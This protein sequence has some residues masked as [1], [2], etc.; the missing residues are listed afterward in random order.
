MAGID[1]DYGFTSIPEDGDYYSSPFTNMTW[2]SANV[3]EPPKPAWRD[4]SLFNFVLWGIIGSSF[5]VL[6]MIGNALSFISFQRDRRTAAVTLLQCLACSDFVLLITVFATDDIPY[7]CSYTEIC[8]N[9]WRVW[10]YI[11]YIWILT[12]MSHM[13]SIWFVV[14]I[15]CNR[16][17]AVC[18]PH[19]MSRFWSIPRTVT[20]AVGVVFLVLAFN[21][22]RFFE[23][24]IITVVKDDNITTYQ[25]E[26]RTAFAQTYPY[27]HVYKAYLVN[28][29]LILMPLFTLILLT[30]PILRAVHVKRR[31]EGGSQMS[32]L[33][34]ASQEITFVLSMVLVVTILCQTPLAI[35]HFVRNAYEYHCGDFVFYLEDVSKLLITVNS[36]VNFIIYCV[37]SQRFRRLFWATILCRGNDYVQQMGAYS[38]MRTITTNCTQ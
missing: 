32:T 9:P 14:L 18:K 8:R 17:W 33:S 15:A 10:P 25:R 19:N 28:V 7:M 35:F 1:N 38:T 3:T 27:T 16:Y 2:I 37:F 13:C 30:I 6:G 24:R 26:T 11:R 4:C 23:Y 20:Y 5:C 31:G 21:L 12:P 34:R 22:P 29:L 36:S